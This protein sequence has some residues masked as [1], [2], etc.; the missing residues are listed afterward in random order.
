MYN[1]FKNKLKKQKQA[2]NRYEYYVKWFLEKEGWQVEHTGRL[3]F[4]DHG[5][6]M[7]A[8]KD[9]ITRYVQCKGWSWWKTLH[10]DVVNQLYGAVVGLEGSERIGREVELYIYSPAKLTPFA[11]SQ[12]D[13]LH[14]HFDRRDFPRWKRKHPYSKLYHQNL[15]K[16]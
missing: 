14:I 12:A 7:I 6:D 13:A 16:Y 8:R 5:I 15:K 2:G 9:G 4:E 10:E 11:Q 1:R 3:G